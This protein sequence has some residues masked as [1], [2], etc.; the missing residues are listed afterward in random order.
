MTRI[1]KS[2]TLSAGTYYIADANSNGLAGKAIETIFTDDG[3]YEIPTSW[4]PNSANF[5]EEYI[6]IESGEIGIFD[7]LYACAL[8]ELEGAFFSVDYD[9]QVHVRGFE[10]GSKIQIVTELDE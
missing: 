1:I 7:N 5:T 8:H 2:Q 4:Q 9:F 10:G 6:D 3:T